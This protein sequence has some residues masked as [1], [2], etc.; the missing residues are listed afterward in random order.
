MV[1]R[2][3]PANSDTGIKKSGGLTQP[4]EEFACKRR[5]DRE[6]TAVNLVILSKDCPKM[7]S[8]F[9]FNEISGTT[10]TLTTNSARKP[11]HPSADKRRTIAS[12][13]SAV[14]VS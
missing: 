1:G 12:T 14:T 6:K 8:H 13:F 10:N 2:S 11:Y 3:G 5:A 4:G 7:R 9:G